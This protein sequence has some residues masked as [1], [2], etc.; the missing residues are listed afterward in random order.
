MLELILLLLSPNGLKRLYK[1]R[2]LLAGI[3]YFG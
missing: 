2:A 1:I 3:I